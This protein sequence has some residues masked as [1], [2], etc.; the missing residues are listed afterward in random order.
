VKWQV[1]VTFEDSA[2]RYSEIR[3]YT[4][5]AEITEVA[6]EERIKADAQA[7]KAALGRLSNLRPLERR[8][9]LFY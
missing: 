8:V 2:T 4:F 9:L 1:Q 3:T 7:I 5:P 6:A